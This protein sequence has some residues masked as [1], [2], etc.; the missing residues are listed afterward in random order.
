M[1]DSICNYRKED[2]WISK[3]SLK[4]SPLSILSPEGLQ[5]RKPGRPEGGQQEGEKML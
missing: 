5:T 2:V 1:S 3:A 4:E